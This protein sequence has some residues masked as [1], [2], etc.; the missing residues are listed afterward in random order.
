MWKVWC[1]VAAM[2]LILIGGSAVFIE[3]HFNT[4]SNSTASIK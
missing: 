2:T 1:A 3:L 4:A